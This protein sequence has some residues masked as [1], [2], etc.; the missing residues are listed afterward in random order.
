VLADCVNELVLSVNNMDKAN[1][2]RR[3]I[4]CGNFMG[5]LHIALM[6]LLGENMDY[7]TN[8]VWP[9]KSGSA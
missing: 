7:E 8:K 5:K 3:A 4:A 6:E 2:E 1:V 9:T